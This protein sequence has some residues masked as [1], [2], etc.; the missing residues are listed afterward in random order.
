MSKNICHPILRKS[1]TPLQEQVLGRVH[2][3]PRA[4]GLLL[5]GDSL[6][7]GALFAVIQVLCSVPVVEGGEAAR[8]LELRQAREGVPVGVWCC[9]R[10]CSGSG[11]HGGGD[12]GSGLFSN[13]SRGPQEG[14]R[15]VFVSPR[16]DP[17]P[18]VH[19][20][21]GDHVSALSARSLLKSVK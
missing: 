16:R 1:D 21:H 20:T 5:C 11:G 8:A 12:G 9:G 7:F 17:V 2:A 6:D 13:V 15:G 14:L 3:A 4:V 19:T 10:T 18:D